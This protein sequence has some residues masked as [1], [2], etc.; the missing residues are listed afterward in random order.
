MICPVCEEPLKKIEGETP[1]VIKWFCPACTN[2]FDDFGKQIN[3]V[4]KFAG[5]TVWEYEEEDFG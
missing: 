5:I 4:G 1:G 2:L 3:K